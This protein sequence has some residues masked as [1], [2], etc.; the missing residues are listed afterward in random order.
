LLHHRGDSIPVNRTAGLRFDDAADAYHATR[1]RYPTQL[2]AA[3]DPPGDTLE[4]GC[5]SGQLTVDLV[6][7]GHRVVAVDPGANLV[8]LA[9]ETCPAVAFTVGTFE[10]TQF[11]SARFDLIASATAFH[12]VDPHVGY[13]KAARLLRPGGRLAV[14]SH[15]IVAGPSSARLDDVVARSAPSFPLGPL[16]TGRELAARVEAAGEFDISAVVAAM[17][18][19]GEA[20]G[21]QR[22]FGTPQVRWI[23][24][25]EQLSG[26]D[27]ALAFAAT[28][29]WGLLPPHEAGALVQG[30]RELASASGGAFS[31]RRVTFL[32]TTSVRDGTAGGRASKGS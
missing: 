20:V 28:T 6:R 16:P 21:A 29:A 13:P 2:V 26:D 11:G 15:R 22:W 3:L 7:R 18:G 14:L 25:D 27:L 30:L 32:A 31:R 9:R 10:E 24:W 4:V 23:E 12:W 19:W 8:L 17:E 5:G 1:P